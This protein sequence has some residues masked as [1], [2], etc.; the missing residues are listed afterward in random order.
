MGFGSEYRW[1]LKGY[2]P[3]TIPMVRLAEY[4]QQLA[5]LLGQEPSV[6]FQKVEKS[7]VALISK[8]DRH[9]VGKVSARL[10]AVRQKTAPI[11]IMRHADWLNTMLADDQ[12]SAILKEG[13]AIILRFPG[14]MGYLPST[15]RVPDRGSVL[16]YLYMLSEAPKGFHARIRVESG[17]ALLCT[18]APAVAKKLRE[19]LFESVKVSGPGLWERSSEGV[20]TAVTLDIEEFIPAD[21][22][23]L[24]AIIDQLRGLGIDWDD[25]SSYEDQDIAEMHGPIQ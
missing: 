4:M 15:L 6:H 19:H 25:Y 20:W 11:E 14:V 5:K 24:R 7:S 10:K 16:G 21:S 17:G 2:S 8:V 22:A 3:E 23:K 1:E 12:T 9:A 13:S 18:A